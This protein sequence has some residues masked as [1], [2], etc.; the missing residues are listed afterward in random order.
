MQKYFAFFKTLSFYFLFSFTTFRLAVKS[1]SN[2]LYCLS[3][4]NDTWCV[5]I[6]L[7]YGINLNVFYNFVN[8]E[9]FLNVK[10]NFERYYYHRTLALVKTLKCSTHTHVV[11]KTV[12]PYFLVRITW[13]ILRIFFWSLRNKYTTHSHGNNNNGYR[14]KTNNT[15]LPDKYRT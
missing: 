4:L 8:L 6:S 15:K 13:I 14:K 10:F 5:T 9:V 7:K 2:F 12:N 3:D 11:R 1:S